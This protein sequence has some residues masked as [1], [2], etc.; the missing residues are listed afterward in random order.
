MGVA[1]EDAMDE[2][3]RDACS[4]RIKSRG[5]AGAV[6]NVGPCLAAGWSRATAL[7]A[8]R[9]RLRLGACQVV[10]A[11]AEAKQLKEYL[12]RKAHSQRM[13]KDKGRGP[14][15]GLATRR[16]GSDAGAGH[17]R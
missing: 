1:R 6:Q 10:S 12:K 5:H 3:S 14:H 13:D 17:A 7:C 16:S 4:S 15:K 11:T 8:L 9:M 2:L